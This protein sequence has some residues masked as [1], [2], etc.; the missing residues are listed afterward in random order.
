MAYKA[1]TIRYSINGTMPQGEIFSTSI[2]TEVDTLNQ[3]AL[4][5]GLGVLADWL[6]TTPYLQLKT[7][8]PASVIVTE[9]AAYGYDGGS[10]AAYQSNG[11]VNIPGT[12]GSAPLPN[13]CAVVTSLLTGRPGRS[14]R[15]RM[16]WPLLAAPTS[17]DGQVSQ[18]GIDLISNSVADLAHAWDGSGTGLP[19]VGVVASLTHGYNTPITDVSVDSR[20]DIQRRRAA[21][22]TILRHST[23]SVP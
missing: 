17:G 4:D 13:Q 12:A 23:H 11:P 5:A 18:T 10:S 3:D 19:Q 8:M 2:C 6:T 9:L 21:S 15:G 14:K 20:F 7:Y 1:G 16:Y 22:E